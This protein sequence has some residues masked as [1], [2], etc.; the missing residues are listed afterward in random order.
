MYVKGT[1]ADEIFSSTENR[2]IFKDLELPVVSAEHLIA[3][4]LFAVQNNPDRKYKDLGD[5]KEILKHSDCN[6]KLVKDYFEKY[7][8]GSLYKEF[9]AQNDQK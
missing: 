9:A 2:L 6:K 1:T 3:M 4:K 7:G 5:I 8:Q